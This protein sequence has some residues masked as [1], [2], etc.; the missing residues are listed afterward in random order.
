[1]SYAIICVVKRNDFV[2]AVVMAFFI[3][4]NKRRSYS[5]KEWSDAISW[6]TSTDA[7]LLDAD[8]VCGRV[9]EDVQGRF[10]TG[11]STAC[12]ICAEWGRTG[13]NLW[14]S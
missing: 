1:M 14:D 11:K 9:A 6:F 7:M 13:G 3:Y 4:I 5:V 2:F 8:I 12:I 10:S